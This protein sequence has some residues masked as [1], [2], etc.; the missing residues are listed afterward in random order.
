MLRRSAPTDAGLGSGELVHDY[1]WYR[2]NS[3]R[4]WK[5]WVV[6]GILVAIWL[7]LVCWAIFLY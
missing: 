4:A 7:A 3:R 2:Q 6:D 1:S 5:W